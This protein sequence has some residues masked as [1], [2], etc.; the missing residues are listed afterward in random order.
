[1][2]VGS[3]LH[4]G[5]NLECSLRSQARDFPS[6]ANPRMGGWVAGHPR[7]TFGDC[8][9]PG[10][11]SWMAMSSQLPRRRRWGGIRTTLQFNTRQ[12]RRSNDPPGASSKSW[13]GATEDGRLLAA[14][15]SGL[16]LE[17]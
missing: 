9:K 14:H 7:A 10:L 2:A 5:A 13:D 17:G 6:H 1:M 8:S 4:V 12:E 16:I 3:L 11:G 15:E